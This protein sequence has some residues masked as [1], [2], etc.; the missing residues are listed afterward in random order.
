M[1]LRL[2][3]VCL[4][5][6]LFQSLCQAADTNLTAD[7]DARLINEATGLHTKLVATGEWSKPVSGG[8]GTSISGRLLVYDGAYF[9]NEFGKQSWFAAPV[10]VEI[11]NEMGF[12]TQIFFN[13][14]KDVRFE[15]RD[16]NGNP[17]DNLKQHGGGSYTPM[18]AQ[19]GTVPADGLLRLR[20]NG[21][22]ATIS[23]ATKREKTGGLGLF[24]PG[25]SWLIPADDTN[26]Y[27]LS[28]TLSS[29]PTNS[30]PDSHAVWRG[31]LEFPAVKLGSSVLK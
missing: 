26:A 23:L 22:I 4:L 29:Q 31:K 8:Q 7:A 17:A 15:L 21:N 25:G 10:F 11:T 16:G 13:W 1:S 28:A 19:W 2:I 30:S 18:R 24:C 20:A 6:A 12:P 9:T 27:F 14:G 3:I 5:T